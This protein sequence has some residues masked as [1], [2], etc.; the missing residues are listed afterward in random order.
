MYI[1]EQ[2]TPIA[3]P[4]QTPFFGTKPHNVL[5]EHLASSREKETLFKLEVLCN[6]D[7]PDTAIAQYLLDDG[8]S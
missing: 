8:E 7:D 5:C 2:V 1:H 4:M 6:S 3:S